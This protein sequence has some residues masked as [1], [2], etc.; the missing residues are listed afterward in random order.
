MALGSVVSEGSTVPSFE[1]ELP[2]ILV[3]DDD[4]AARSLLLE[5][6]DRRYG[7]DYDV[8]AESSAADAMR[9]LEDLHAAG[10]WSR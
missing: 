3:V 2:T 7:H 9:R 10:R 8:T 4:D 6:V 1:D 5:A